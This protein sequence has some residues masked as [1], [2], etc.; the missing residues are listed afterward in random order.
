MDPERLIE[1]GIEKEFLFA[2][3]RSSGPG[4]Q[5]VNKVNTRV[6]IRF[7]VVLSYILTE[8]EKKLVLNNIKRKINSNGELIVFSQSERSQLKNREKA[9]RKLLEILSGSLSEKQERIPTSPTLK[10]K[11]ERLEGKR[12]LSFRKMLR[13][14][15]DE[16][17]E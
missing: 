13:K 9:T 1:R 4:G 8:E 6:E 12:R 3:S 15:V 14:D 16:D 11:S 5:N 10:S 17:Y 2:A 7:N